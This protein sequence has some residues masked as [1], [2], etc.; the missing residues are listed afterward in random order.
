MFLREF[1]SNCGSYAGAVVDTNTDGFMNN[2]EET[3]YEQLGAAIGRLV[4]ALLSIALVLLLGKYLW[5]N[6]AVKLV[7]ALKPA[8]S[9]Y[10][11]LGLMV[12]INLLFC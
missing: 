11:I 7:G 2:G 10:E 9:I 1:F 6:A 8:K 3:N 4:G 5:N 12:L